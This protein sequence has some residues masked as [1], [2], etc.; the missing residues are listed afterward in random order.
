MTLWFITFQKSGSTQQKLHFLAESLENKV[1]FN[2]GNASQALPSQKTHRGHFKAANLFTKPSE[3]RRRQTKSGW[4]EKKKTKN[5]RGK[6]PALDIKSRERGQTHSPPGRWPIAVA[7][8]FTF[9]PFRS[10]PLIVLCLYC[11]Q[12]EGGARGRGFFGRALQRGF[13]AVIQSADDE[14]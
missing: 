14:R 11:A 5:R 9:F 6:S 8:E 1:T 2:S 12:D 7:S 13:L 4:T 3:C 10:R